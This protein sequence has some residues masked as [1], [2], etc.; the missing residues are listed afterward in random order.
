MPVDG[1]ALVPP[2]RVSLQG[3]PRR[4]SALDQVLPIYARPD[5]EAVPCD[6]ARIHRQVSSPSHHCAKATTCACARTAGIDIGIGLRFLSGAFVELSDEGL[7]QAPGQDLHASGQRILLGLRSGSV[8][9]VGTSR[10]TG[11]S[12]VIIDCACCGA[13]G[14]CGSAVSSC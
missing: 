6:W 9:A 14:S 3:E 5:L 10:T 8:L 4:P 11:V 13:L 12:G 2:G 1:S 7:A